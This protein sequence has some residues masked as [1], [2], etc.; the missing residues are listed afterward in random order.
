MPLF[1][2]EDF[3][4]FK[5][6]G[7]V[8]KNDAPEGF[9]LLRALYDKLGQLCDKI[10]EY[11]N[12][13]YSYNIRRDPSVRGT[14]YWHYHWAQL[15]LCD[16][17]EFRN[18]CYDKIFF[19]IHTDKNGFACHIDF[20]DTNQALKDAETDAAIDI[21]EASWASL[22]PEEVSAMKTAEIADYVIRYMDRH[23]RD[24]YRYGQEFGITECTDRL[25][26][27]KMQ[28]YIDLLTANRNLVLTG[29]PGTGKTYLARQIAAQMIL[30]KTDIDHLTDAEQIL[31]SH[32]C[33]MVQ[34]HPS[35][36]YT[37]F[38]EGLRPTPP[39]AN[40]NIGFRRANG[41]FKQ[42]CADALRSSISNK[43]IVQAIE[44][45]K[46]TMNGK[47]IPSIRTSNMEFGIKIKDG[48]IFFIPNAQLDK[49]ENEQNL[50]PARIQDVISYITTGEYDGAHQS[51]EP[52]LGEYL[53]KTYLRE[54]YDLRKI[55][56][57]FIIDEINR[58]E[59]AKIFGELFFAIDPGYR[60]EKGRV[61]TQYQNLITDD[62]DPFKA[63]FYVPDNVYILGT[64][65]DI[66]RS[67]DTMDFAIRRRFAWQ[68]VTADSTSG[69][70]D[71][72][73]TSV[74][75]SALRRMKKLNDAIGGHRALGN[76]FHIGASYFLKISNY[77]ASHSE[78]EAFD[79][80]WE[81]HLRGLLA[82]YLRGTSDAAATLQSLKTAYQG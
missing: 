64:M 68:E 39:D 60:G 77:L 58:G 22:S 2:V 52:A 82:E 28:S 29:A 81:H 76:A 80:L 59:I 35:M 53:K 49:P 38:V 24:F 7:H 73:D 55:P 54:F 63:G 48:N 61:T 27:L 12:S 57:I 32:C 18:A 4:L 1:Q 41:I 72:L 19:V 67:V 46:A 33:R 75:A 3:E 56:Y 6:Y 36:D 25:N 17:Q 9:D 30:G 50:Y 21:K 44:H 65:N 14:K 71:A 37:D 34:F 45:F 8:A 62:N 78:E 20:R 40:G 51:Y 31:L 79:L 42:F 70:L 23:L 13:R 11:S 47:R 66:D 43:E 69:M 15:Y 26:Q 74:R 5:R 10:R 16:T